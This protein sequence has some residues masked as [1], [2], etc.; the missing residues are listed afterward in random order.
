MSMKY[1]RLSEFICCL[2]GH[3]FNQTFSVTDSEIDTENVLFYFKQCRFC[4]IT[5]F[6]Q[7]GYMKLY[8][9]KSRQIKNELAQQL[10]R[11]K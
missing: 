8:D 4:G 1:S 9:L 2:T 3:D 7:T 5:I 10:Q 6:D 11:K